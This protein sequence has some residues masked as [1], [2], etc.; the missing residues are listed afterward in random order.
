[1]FTG[2]IGAV[3]KVRS[4][5]G[6]SGL[7]RTLTIDLGNLT[8]SCR[9]GDSIA[10]NGACLTV[11]RLDGR[12]ATFDLS[13]ETLDV[14]TLGT[15]RPQS[16]VNVELAMQA[17]G[18]FGGHI[19]LGHVDGT[20]TIRALKNLD[21]FADIEFAADADLL[22]QMVVKGSVAVD[23]ISLTVAGISQDSFGVAVIP[24]TLSKT[25]LGQAKVGDRVN[26]ETDLLVKTIK[27]HLDNVLP[28]EEKL[29]LERLRQ[30]GF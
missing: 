18:R 26:I 15:L 5:S 2:L 4:I 30:L 19:V 23:G 11:A 24:Q 1:M 29:T 20:A 14:S 10:V 16:E 12:L 7:G 13:A 25:T 3:C 27:K 17:T 9:I 8:D 22:S 21:R 28:Q 6:S